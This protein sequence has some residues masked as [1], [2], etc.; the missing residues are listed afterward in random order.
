M[1]NADTLYFLI[2]ENRLFPDK[3]LPRSKKRSIFS[4]LTDSVNNKEIQTIILAKKQPRN[5]KT[6]TTECSELT[7][8]S[9]ETRSEHERNTFP[10]NGKRTSCSQNT[11]SK[12]YKYTFQ[13][14][15][16]QFSRINMQKISVNK[17]YFGDFIQ[18]TSKRKEYFSIFL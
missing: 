13:S 15:F 1:S 11:D 17:T 3:G 12:L 2:A 7:S 14:S 10:A 9:D 18:K 16:I 5:Q 8:R 4:Y 6:S